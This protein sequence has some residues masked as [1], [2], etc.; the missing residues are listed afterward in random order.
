MRR[1]FSVEKKL[2]PWYNFQHKLCR[3]GKIKLAYK[4]E[5]QRPLELDRPTWDMLREN[6]I[7]TDSRRDFRWRH[8]P[9]KENGVI[10]AATY[11]VMSYEYADDVVEKDFPLSPDVAFRLERIAEKEE[12]TLEKYLSDL[13]FEES[14][15]AFPSNKNFYKK[16]FE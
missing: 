1:P 12:K 2:L 14:K 10:H 13:I 3:K 16:F 9:D 4:R 11:T 7:Y 5:W 15:K 6:N 8:C